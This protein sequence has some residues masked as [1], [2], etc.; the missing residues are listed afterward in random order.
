MSAYFIVC[1]GEVEDEAA[2]AE[3]RRLAMPTLKSAGAIFRTRNGP[4]E[5]L[6]GN[7]VQ[8]V[9]VVEFPS[10]SAISIAALPAQL[11]EIA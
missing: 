11:P 8:R 9:I 4:F 5:T 3:Y 7:P 6:E 2:F 1:L 10:M